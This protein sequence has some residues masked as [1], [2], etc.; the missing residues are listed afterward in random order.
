M[1][2]G[3]TVAAKLSRRVPVRSPIAAPKWSRSR[4]WMSRPS[5][6]GIRSGGDRRRLL[7]HQPPLLLDLLLQ[8]DETLGEG[9]RARRTAG[10]VDVDRDHL[11]DAVADR[12]GELEEPTAVGAAPH[13]DDVL[14]IGHLVVEHLR[15]ER[16]L[17]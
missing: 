3:S 11:V 9:F 15:A 1:W 17:E 14:R 13:R 16:H 6:A 2:A 4:A 8:L 7:P 10:N 12:V 5:S